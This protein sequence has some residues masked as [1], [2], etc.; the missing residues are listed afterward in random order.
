[1]RVLSDNAITKSDVD[2]AVGAIDAKQTRQIIQLRIA[3]AIV[4][5]SNVALTM[6][7]KFL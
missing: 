7:L 3:L 2:A 5:I 6:A 4:C 1:M